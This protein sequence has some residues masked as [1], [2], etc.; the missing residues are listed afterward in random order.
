MYVGHD[1]PYIMA[2]VKLD[3]VL[4]YF[5]WRG[6]FYKQLKGFGM[7]KS[8][9]SPLSDIFMEDFEASALA[10]YPTG[11]SNISPSEIILFW[12]RKADDT[13][14]VIHKDHIQSQLPQLHSPRHQVDQ[15]S[16][17]K[18]SYSYARRENHSQS[19]R[20][21]SLRCLPQ[22]NPHQLIHTIQ[23]P[24]TTLP[25]ILHHPLTQSSRLSDSLN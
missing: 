25:Q 24:S 3:L 18:W 5:Q 11:D 19:R 23:Q 9:S 10:N 20:H 14:I 16:R 7:G 15:G 17:A 6:L 2:L 8:T 4:A 13:I 22:A 21:T 12:F 1:G